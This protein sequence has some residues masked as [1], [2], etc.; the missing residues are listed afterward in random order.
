MITYLYK[1]APVKTAETFVDA[2]L[3][4]AD[5][6]GCRLIHLSGDQFRT[7]WQM[8]MKYDD[9]PEI[10]FTDFTSMVVMQDLGMTEVFTGDA[11]FQQVGLG[12]RILP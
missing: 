8:R 12:F 3:D 10:S 1:V 11:H 6:G 7:A 2:L 9:K 4:D 5:T